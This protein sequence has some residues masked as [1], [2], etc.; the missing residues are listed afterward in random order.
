[1]KI[2]IIW[3]WR[4]QKE[5][6]RIEWKWPFFSFLFFSLFLGSASTQFWKRFT[7]SHEH[8]QQSLN[9][10][11]NLEKDS[12]RPFFCVIYRF[13]A[14][15]IFFFIL[16]FFPTQNSNTTDLNGLHSIWY[17]MDFDIRINHEFLCSRKVE[18]DYKFIE[19]AF[20]LT[21]FHSLLIV[22]RESNSRFMEFVLANVKLIWILVFKQTHLNCNDRTT[23]PK[24]CGFHWNH[25]VII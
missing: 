9:R 17:W 16:S 20:S 11:L 6:E 23:K 19:F 13:L 10:I 3:K 7:F 2:I 1:M 25:W 8:P 5:Y 18:C 24:W 15:N 14:R 21:L 4:E 12:N 22:Y